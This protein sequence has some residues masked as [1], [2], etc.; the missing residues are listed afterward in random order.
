MSLFVYLWAEAEGNSQLRN[1]LW[2]A[3][4]WR[5]RAAGIYDSEARWQILYVQ[6]GTAAEADVIQLRL[7]RGLRDTGSGSAGEAIVWSAQGL[8][9]RGDE[10]DFLQAV[11]G[12]LDQF[13]TEYLR[14]N[15]ECGQ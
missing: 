6:V 7:H 5:L 15:P 2:N 9:V 10:Q 3:A 13:I 1:G 4:E 11:S 12:K 14:A 8:G